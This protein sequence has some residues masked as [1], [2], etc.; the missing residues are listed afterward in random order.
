MHTFLFIVLIWFVFLM[1]LPKIRYVFGITWII[2]LMILKLHSL[3][4]RLFV[5][6]KNEPRSNNLDNNYYH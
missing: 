1:T 2:Q 5:G 3:Y 4:L 6:I